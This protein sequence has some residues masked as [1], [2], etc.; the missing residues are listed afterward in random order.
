MTWLKARYGDF[1]KGRGTFGS[2]TTH[3]DKLVP[4]IL[5]GGAGGCPVLVCAMTEGLYVDDR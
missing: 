5:G 2:S 1:D 3:V 4:R